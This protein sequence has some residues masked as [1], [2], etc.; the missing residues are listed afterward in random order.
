MTLAA[1][2][3]P[4]RHSAFRNLA[5][6][7]LISLLG[8][9][10][11]PIALAFAVLDLTHSA[12]DLGLVVG[13]RSLTNVAFVLFGG[14]I[15]DRLPRHLVMVGSSL[16]AAA[17]QTAVAALV[18][19]GSATVPLLMALSA[20]NGMVSAFSLP[21]TAALMPQTVPGDLLQQANALNR[22]AG[23]GAMI[24][25]AAL[26]GALV[27]T[28][29]PGWGLVADAATFAVSA[30]FFALVRVTDVRDR[31][32]PRDGV[33]A[34]LRV[35]WTEFTSRSWVWIIVLAFMVLNATWVGGFYVLGPVVAD[36]TVGRSGWGVVL[37]TVTAGMVAGALVALRL[38]L[39]RPLLVGCVC[40]LAEVV[41]LVA[42]AEWPGSLAALVVVGFL[43]GAA[44]E[45]FSIAWDMSL[46]Q[47]IP[48]DR[49]A[50]V[51]A[52][53]IL[54]SILAVPLGQIAAGPAAAAIGTSNALLAAAGIN[55]VVVLAMIAS[56]GVR[57]LHG[58][59]PA[60][61][62]PDPVTA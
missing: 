62:T 57:S 4:L 43:S 10:V 52:Y 56:R 61:A 11:A 42:L 40:M 14:V 17:T 18:L 25:G 21:A 30:L 1:A 37:A 32:A 19:T 46:Q 36:G 13:A 41:F 9:A 29:G 54:G 28:A 55:A 39:R 31:T 34:E 53:D 2:L 49:L 38:K 27:A 5:L 23:N 6:G 20:V 8:N 45:Q 58:P 3:S 35:G 50:R 16:M 48:A 33:L 12:S 60:P 24:G 51:Y 15:A 59:A 26:G 47:H 22:L 44:V 7:R